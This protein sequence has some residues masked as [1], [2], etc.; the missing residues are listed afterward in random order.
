MRS[1]TEIKTSMTDAFMADATVRSLY[2]LAE[3]DRFGE[4][5]SA[6]SLE[7]ILFSVVASCVYVVESLFDRHRQ[8]VD[9]IAER[10]AVASIPWYHDKVVAYQHGDALVLNEETMAY[11]YEEVAPERQVVKYAAV[12][13]MGN[14]LKIMASG[15][16]NG[17]PAKLTDEQLAGLA[18]Y[19][20]RMKIAGVMTSVVSA[21]ADRIQI[22]A[23]VVVDPLVLR[24]DGSRI[25]DGSFPVREAVES[26]L[27]GIVYGGKLNK[28]KL[29]DAMQ[30]A[31]GVVDVMLTSVKWSTDGG[32]TF[33]EVAGNNYE[34]LGGCFAASGIENTLSYVV[35]G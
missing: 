22:A 23:Q 24:T 27:A 16:Q 15:D 18:E 2:G 26:Y 33:H 34:A 9:E 13:D 30:E 29:V 25:T 6:V 8:E 35:E 5:F 7:N 14:W 4:R 3:G 17:T 12:R 21:D 11:G 19:V 31:V 10:A 28:T 1:I 32:N 20:D